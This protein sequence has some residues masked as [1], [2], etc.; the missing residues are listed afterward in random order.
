MAFKD[1]ILCCCSNK[2]NK[3]YLETLVTVRKDIEHNLDII[4]VLRRLRAHGNCLNFLLDARTRNEC[5]K[6]AGARTGVE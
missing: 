4:T 1:F 2:T 6:I 3:A 5:T